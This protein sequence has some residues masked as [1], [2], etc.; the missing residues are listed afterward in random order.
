MRAY[1]MDL[2]VRVFADVDAGMTFAQVGRKYTVSAE[3]VRQIVRRREQTGETAPRPPIPRRVPFHR[4][5]EA[6]LRAAVAEQPDLTLD[7]LRRRL[8]LE[9]SLSTLWTALQTL[10]ITFKKNAR[11]GRAAAARHRRATPG[12][13]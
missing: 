13:P 8:G 7:E 12:I 6:T 10:K 5:H 2:R 1:S 9:C 3:W 11:A 4:R